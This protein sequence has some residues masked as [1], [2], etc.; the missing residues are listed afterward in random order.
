MGLWH[1]IWPE[2]MKEPYGSVLSLSHKSRCSSLKSCQALTEDILLC[3]C[4]ARKWCYL[5]LLASVNI[6][7]YSQVGNGRQ[8]FLESFCYCFPL[9]VD[10]WERYS[11]TKVNVFYTVLLCVFLPI[12]QWKKPIPM[13]TL[14]LDIWIW[15]RSSVLWQRPL[16]CNK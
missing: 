1:T 10:K 6:Y 14:L 2:I 15:F 7:I 8:D 4:I 5:S 9:Y 3:L 13:G 12:L 11:T 16:A